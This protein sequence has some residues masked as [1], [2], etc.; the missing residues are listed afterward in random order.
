MERK[1]SVFNVLCFNGLKLQIPRSVNNKTGY[2][3]TS[4]VRSG[5]LSR[6]EFLNISLAEG[7]PNVF[8]L[9]RNVVTHTRHKISLIIHRHIKSAARE[10]S[11]GKEYFSKINL[12]LGNILKRTKN[13]LY[14]PVYLKKC[15]MV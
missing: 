3:A 14:V 10:T 12:Y 13:I 11:G 5:M 7:H 15:A 9:T 1:I 8:I 6:P 4:Y 2:K